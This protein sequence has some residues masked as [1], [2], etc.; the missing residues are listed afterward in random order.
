MS[1]ILMVAEAGTLL[2]AVASSS[3]QQ[4]GAISNV[5]FRAKLAH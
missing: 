2:E 3:N 5:T 1:N 4:V